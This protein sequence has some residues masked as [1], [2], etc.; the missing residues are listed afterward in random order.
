MWFIYPIPF[1]IEAKKLLV[2]V[3]DSFSVFEKSDG[4]LGFIEF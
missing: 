2:K 1:S 3:P 4:V